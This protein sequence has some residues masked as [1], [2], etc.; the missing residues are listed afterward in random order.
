M[1]FRSEAP[2]AGGSGQKGSKKPESGEVSLVTFKLPKPAG[3]QGRIDARR[4][5]LLVYKKKQAGLKKLFRR[6]E[7][8]EITSQEFYEELPR[9][10]SFEAGNRFQGLGWERHGKGCDFQ[11]LSQSFLR[12]LAAS[13]DDRDDVVVEE[14]DRLHE[15]G[16][17][18]RGAF[19]SEMLCLRFPEEYPVLNYPVKEYLKA[20]KY[21]AP[22]GASEGVRFIFLAKSLRASL[23]QNPEHPAKNLAELDT[24][25]WLKHGKK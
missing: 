24:V 8:G 15:L 12:V 7:S 13:N 14:I 11:L 1:L 22:R 17:R 3:M 23:L 20:V 9:Y 2:S 19:L 5:Q 6:C 21:K 16:V 10:W 4:Q 25:I 18:A